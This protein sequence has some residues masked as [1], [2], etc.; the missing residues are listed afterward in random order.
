M[1]PPKIAAVLIVKATDDEAKLLDQC[2]ESIKGSVDGIYVVLT[3][4][5]DEMVSKK[6]RGVVEAHNASTYVYQ[7]DNNFV[8]ARTFS[9]SKVPKKFGWI[10]W[11]DSDDTVDHPEKMRDVAA[12]VSPKVDGVYIRYDYAHDEYGNVTV[13]HYVARLVRNNDSFK[14]QSSIDDAKVAVHETL[15]EA[16]TAGKV[17]NDEFK[18]V[19]HADDDR[20]GASLVRNIDLLEG[21]YE[22]Q[23]KKGR[24]DAR[25]LFYL[26]TH[27]FDAQNYMQA[28]IKLQQ[29]MQLSG[30]P[31]ERSEALVYLG[32]IYARED[33]LDQAEHAF[34]LALRENPDNPRPYVELAE[35]EYDQGRYEN[36]ATWARKAMECKKKTTTMVLRPMDAT[37]RAYMLY[38][39]AVVNVGGDKL[40]EAQEYIDKALELRPFDPEA[41]DAQELIEDLIEK[42]N[43]NRA[44]VRMARAN[45]ESENK[46]DAL[47]EAVPDKIGDSPAV[48]AIRVDHVKPKTWPK[49]SMVI[50]CGAGPLG[51]WGPKSLATG[52]GGSEEAVIRLSQELNKQG[53]AV[54]VFATPGPETGDQGGVMWKNYWDFNPNDTFDVLVSWRS[55]W[56]W[57]TK[58]KAR[59]TYLWMHDV[60]PKSEFYDERLENISKV[61]LLSEY[62]R[63]LFPNIPDEKVFLSSNGITPEDFVIPAEGR[64][65]Y[66]ILWMSS[67]VRGLQLLYDMWPSIKKK[68]PEATLDC[69]YGWESFV[70]VH[71]DNPERM[72]WMHMMQKLGKKL[73]GVTD[74]GKVGQHDIVREINKSGIWAYPCPF[75]EISCITAMKAQAG[76]A[77]PVSSD[78]AALKETVKFGVKVH[79]SQV[80][81][82]QPIGN[83]NKKEVANYKRELVKLLKDPERQ[84]SIRSAM[85]P[86]SRQIFAWKGVAEQW[87]K[88]MQ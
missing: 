7:W 43:L 28:K 53:W 5:K 48:A 86:Q 83:W 42:R 50:F 63:S 65:P 35:L 10:L 62:H 39:Q 46:M 18:V 38:A 80:D 66:R 56:F 84:Q 15:V 23:R 24:F 51:T 20:R 52:I 30:W 60:M 57:E 11:L 71:Q 19:H 68:V 41:K 40:T 8:N 67:H 2:L 29:Y 31:E 47:L 59:K 79:M 75:P 69:Y 27:Y 85:M 36:S 33:K 12:I 22:R 58:Y 81:E 16:R 21:M 78:F 3:H 88:E 82:Q 6:V 34:V 37:Y 64:D 72:G 44:F 9:F 13:P 14:W 77:I 54:T 76:G 1:K 49:K 25:I 87:S 26:G 70:A 32:V 73:D 55:P 17:M 4:K 45:K 74:H 61:I